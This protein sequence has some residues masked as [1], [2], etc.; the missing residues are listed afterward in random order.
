MVSEAWQ[1]WFAS[2]SP[3]INQ[4]VTLGNIS[5]PHW[6]DGLRVSSLPPSKG[7]VW[8]P[9]NPC[10]CW[11]LWKQPILC[12]HL[13]PQQFSSHKIQMERKKKSSF[14]QKTY[15]WQLY[16]LLYLWNLNNW[17]I[18]RCG[19]HRQTQA[20]V[21][22]DFTLGSFI[23]QSINGWN[24]TTDIK[25]FFLPCWVCWKKLISLNHKGEEKL[26]WI[27]WEVSVRP[28]SKFFL[29]PLKC[30]LLKLDGHKIICMRISYNE[31]D[32]M[33]SSQGNILKE[34]LWPYLERLANRGAF[35][36]IFS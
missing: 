35:I 28:E 2:W 16:L 8:C 17:I 11:G 9:G 33:A 34:R 15:V 18:K 21:K 29:G 1:P 23:L 36:H 26:W 31:K 30:F 3:P 20:A 4:P 5:Y 7:T 13:C 19:I 14:P 24:V 27:R 6:L 12:S 25:N 10:N 32:C 22:T